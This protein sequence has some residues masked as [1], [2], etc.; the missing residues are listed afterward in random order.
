MVQLL[1]QVSLAELATKL[2]F[3][4][5]T[6]ALA[7]RALQVNLG[8]DLDHVL[9][10]ATLQGPSSDYKSALQ[11]AQLQA[12]DMLQAIGVQLVFLDSV[13]VAE[14][15]RLAQVL[16][17]AGKYAGK[18]IVFFWAQRRGYQRMLFMDNDYAPLVD[19]RE[20][21]KLAGPDWPFV[22]APDPMPVW[23]INSGMFVV[24]LTPSLYT[25]MVQVLSQIDFAGHHAGDSDQDLINYY[26]FMGSNVSSHKTLLATYN[27][28]PK[29]M[30]QNV[31]GR[32]NLLLL[33]RGDSFIRGLH[34]TMGRYSSHCWATD[35]HPPIYPTLARLCCFVAQLVQRNATTEAWG[36]TLTALP[37]SRA[38]DPYGCDNVASR[39]RGLKMYY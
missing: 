27:F 13:H 19:M 9:L 30:M 37:G 16:P 10:L 24:W 35:L 5:F 38:V 1:Y 4:F 12:L 6:Q 22:S 33:P 23:H 21:A 15:N 28:M 2:D 32:P 14:M 34:L 8:N 25:D 31:R 20:V 26:F 36:R 3:N 7:T 11:P 18:M 29:F 39:A 17:S